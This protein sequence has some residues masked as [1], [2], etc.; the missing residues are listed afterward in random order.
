MGEE[1][2]REWGHRC[3]ATRAPET[4]TQRYAAI[5]LEGWGVHTRPRPTMIRGAGPDQPWDA[6]MKD[7]LQ[8]ARGHKQ[9]GMGTC[10]RSSERPSPPRIVLHTANVLRA[11]EIHTWGHGAATI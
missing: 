2:A 10:P 9:D 1:R 3:T 8:A 7:W 6:V 4:P 5:L 11:T